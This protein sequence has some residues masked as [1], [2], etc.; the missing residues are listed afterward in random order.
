MPRYTGKDLQAAIKHARVELDIPT[1]RIAELYGVDRKTLRRRLLGTHQDN[2][3]AHR[4]E[5]LLSTGVAKAIAVC[6][7]FRGPLLEQGHRMTNS[8]FRTLG[9]VSAYGIKCV[10][11]L[12]VIHET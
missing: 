8:V 6:S 10:G 9:P 2:S 4:D 7:V 11:D 3:T 5:Q 12:D 1:I